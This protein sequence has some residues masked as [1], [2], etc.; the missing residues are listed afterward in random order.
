MK[1]HE[2]PSPRIQ[3][4]DISAE[5]GISSRRHTT[6]TTNLCKV[7]FCAQA[8]AHQHYF[9]SHTI[10]AT[11]KTKHSYRF[12]QIDTQRPTAH[13]VRCDRLFSPQREKVLPI[14]QQSIPIKLQSAL[15]GLNTSS[16]VACIRSSTFTSEDSE[17]PSR[18]TGWNWFSTLKHGYH[19]PARK[20]KQARY[21]VGG[22]PGG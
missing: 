9:P 20:C 5:G 13:C 2:G 16:F 17:Y 12:M 1:C 15:Q 6:K 8:C 4:E 10:I 7:S 22:V 14:P 3:S 18:P 11:T 19:L 21:C